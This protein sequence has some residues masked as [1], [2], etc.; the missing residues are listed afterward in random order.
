MGREK[1]SIKQITPIKEYYCWQACNNS[2][3]SFFAFLCLSK[4]VS[5]LDKVL[6]STVCSEIT[7]CDKEN[8]DSLTTDVQF[9]NSH[10]GKKEL[11]RIMSASALLGWHFKVST[12]REAGYSLSIPDTDVTSS[13]VQNPAKY[14]THYKASVTQHFPLKT[15]PPPPSLTL[16]HPAPTT[17]T[18]LSTVPN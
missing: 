9:I 5:R 8:F 14:H 4:M 2:H 17:T 16:I 1:F 18:W 13:T 3:S 12:Q 7:V 10:R 11:Q 6:L 15:W